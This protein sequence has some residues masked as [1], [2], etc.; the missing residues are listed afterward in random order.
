MMLFHYLHG[1]YV[2]IVVLL[3]CF[4][5]QNKLLQCMFHHPNST[6]FFVQTSEAA[7]E[8]RTKTPTTLSR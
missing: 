7:H 3:F 1:G 8:K 4:G 5:L 6:E 2:N